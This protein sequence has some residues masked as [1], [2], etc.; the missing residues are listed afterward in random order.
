MAAGACPQPTAAIIRA[1]GVMETAVE[2][3]RGGGD[4]RE[5]MDA[6]RAAR[7]VPCVDRAPPPLSA[8]REREPPTV[9]ALDFS[10][11]GRAHV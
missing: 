9:S 6:H 2:T 1:A 10:Q 11:I 3:A 5:W 7:D 8:S 4:G